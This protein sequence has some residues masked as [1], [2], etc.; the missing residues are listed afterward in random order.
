MYLSL[1]INGNY[2][3][4]NI[5]QPR[6]YLNYMDNALKFFLDDFLFFLSAHLD[7]NLYFVH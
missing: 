7:N 3:L 4:P 1:E 6:R 5:C 2:N